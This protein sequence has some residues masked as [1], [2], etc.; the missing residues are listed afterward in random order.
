M[1]ILRIA[2]TALPVKNGASIHVHHLSNAQIDLGHSVLVLTP[3]GLENLSTKTHRYD[4]RIIGG[5]QHSWMGEP[6]TE[7]ILFRSKIFALLYYLKI[8]FSIKIKDFDIIHIHGDLPD[9]FLLPLYK[10]LAPKTKFFLT[11]HGGVSENRIYKRLMAVFVGSLNGLIAVNEH[12][13]RD[14]E[15]SNNKRMLKKT[16]VQS[17]GVDKDFFTINRDHVVSNG[18]INLI[19]IGRLHKVKGVNILLEAYSRLGKKFKL[20]IY[21]D[22]PELDNLIKQSHN[23]KTPRPVEFFG[24]VPTLEVFRKLDS[25]AILIIPSIKL[26]SQKEGF[27]TIAL[28]AMA[29]RIPI[30][31]SD[32]AGLSAIL[33]QM[34]VFE[35]GDFTALVN[36]LHSFNFDMWNAQSLRNYAQKQEWSEVS[37]RITCFMEER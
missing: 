19:F 26:T 5:F 3:Y 18:D 32:D 37:K 33:P 17:S 35:S 12:I 27:P 2:R 25:R 20:E 28:E 29:A 9:I 10:I 15:V 24:T 8:V 7:H 1:N 34:Q 22:G 4:R 21:G 14:L 11:L 16:F 23:I 36:T 13:L 31:A 30:I 6:G